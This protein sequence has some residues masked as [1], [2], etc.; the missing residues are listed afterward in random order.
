[1]TPINYARGLLRRPYGKGGWRDHLGIV[2]HYY[3]PNNSLA[4]VKTAC[5]L[6]GRMFR[7]GLPELLPA[8]LG[9]MPCKTCQKSLEQR[10]DQQ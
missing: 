7:R 3:G 2:D 6:T 1:M 4:R 8:A 10:K 5:G 9:S